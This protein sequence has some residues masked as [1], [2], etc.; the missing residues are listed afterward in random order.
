MNIDDVQEE[1]KNKL[2]GRLD[3]LN[4]YT[5]FKGAVT[6]PA[7]I[8]MLPEENQYDTT[9]GR[10]S[11][12]IRMDLVFLTGKTDNEAA[13]REAKDYASGTGPRSVKQA[14]DP[15]TDR[16]QWKKLDSLSVVSSEFDVYTNGGNE[17]LAT[18]FHLD[19]TGTGAAP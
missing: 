17:Y 2:R 10:G 19:I 18:I 1:I 5:F 14:L 11:D 8:L 16:I 9:M 3:K 15:V 6:P 12:R 4:V 13:H 7:A